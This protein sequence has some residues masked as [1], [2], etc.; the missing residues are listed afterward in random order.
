MSSGDDSTGST[1]CPKHAGQ[2]PGVD[3]RT[4]LRAG[5]A[6]TVIVALPFACGQGSSAPPSGPIAAGNVSAVTVGSLKVIDNAVLGRDAAGLYAMTAVCTHQGC[7]VEAVSATV[8]LECPC[9]HSRFDQHGAVTQ[10]PAASPLQHLKVDL[11]ASGAI[12][13]QGSV[14][15]ASTDRTP[16]P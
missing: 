11:D 4:I 14:N 9:H 3:R 1:L 6:G 5:T 16:V 2:Y 8:A 12:T 15:V 10:G 7:T 13:I